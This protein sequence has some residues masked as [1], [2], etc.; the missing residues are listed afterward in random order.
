[1]A[2]LAESL[3]AEPGRVAGPVAQCVRVLMERGF[4]LPEGFVS[5]EEQGVET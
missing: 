2:H 4:L 1:V 5:E 3:H